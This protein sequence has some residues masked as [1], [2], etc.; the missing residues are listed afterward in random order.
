MTLK[1]DY[2]L[3]EETSIDIGRS[4]RVEDKR[5]LPA[6][7]RDRLNQVVEVDGKIIRLLSP[8]GTRLFDKLSAASFYKTSLAKGFFP[9]TRKLSEEEFRQGN[10]GDQWQAALEHERLPF[11]SYPY[12]W[13]FQMLKRGALFELDL[14]LAALTEGFSLK[15]GSG[16]NLQWRGVAPVHIDIPSLE[17]LAEGSV[18]SGYRQFCQFFLFP[19]M[20]K[21]YKRVPFN[22]WLRSEIDGIPLEHFAPLFG[23]F[24]L[25]RGGVLKHVFLHNKL[26][27]VAANAAGGIAGD[28][29]VSGFHKELIVANV[30]GLRRL[31]A[32]LQD[33]TAKSQWS[34]YAEENSYAQQEHQVKKEFVENAASAIRP[35]LTWD[36]GCNTGGFSKIAAKHS[37]YVVA[38]DND[39]LC[40]DRFFLDLESGDYPN[41]LPLVVSFADPSPNLGWRGQERSSIIERG[42]PDLV[43]AL[44]VIH[45]AVI[46]CN[47]P[48]SQFVAW[49]AELSPTAVIEFV[50]KDD[51]MT[52]KLL[53]NR[54]DQYSD[55]SL[56]NFE[57]CCEAHYKIVRSVKLASG[58][59]FLYQLEK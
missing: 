34:D 59:R 20:L 11:I 38:F 54:I 7:F 6:S 32:G 58:T 53:A 18:W 5:F 12:E 19:L 9:A 10:F 57:R 55:Y 1:A 24:D 43:L 33:S 26:S 31:I 47:I 17:P 23:W 25:L 28:I 40:I 4:L 14:Q 36:I 30:K 2:K 52:K 56:E 29:K 46:S 21:A 39:S 3:V 22:S 37:G 35:K 50:S 44:A 13:S 51:R 16:F 49:I 8:E 27:R 42:K 45:H 48:L 41:I 15:D